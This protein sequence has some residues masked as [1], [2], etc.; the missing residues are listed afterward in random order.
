MRVFSFFKVPG[1]GLRYYFLVPRFHFPLGPFPLERRAENRLRVHMRQHEP[2]TYA[3]LPRMCADLSTLLGTIV[4]CM[5]VEALSTEGA[6]AI[7]YILSTIS[8]PESHVN[9]LSDE[10]VCLGHPCCPNYTNI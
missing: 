9:C 4:P 5:T 8:Y 10:R 7:C 6:Y 3:P 1:T 2:S